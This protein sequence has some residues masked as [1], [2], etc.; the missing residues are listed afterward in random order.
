MEQICNK[1]KENAI[2]VSAL[3]IGIALVLGTYIVANSF[4]RVKALANVVSVTGSA[5]KVIT[6][7]IVKWTSSCSRTV[8][9]Y[10]LKSGSEKIKDDLSIIVSYLKEKGVREEDITIDPV[11]V[12]TTCADYN[13]YSYDKFGNRLCAANQISGYSLQQTI[14]IESSD[15][16][17]V[18]KLAQNATGD[19]INK[20]VIFSSQN[21]EYY[22]K[23][24]ADL[25]VEMLSEATKNAKNRAEKIANSTGAKIGFL[26]SA[27]MGVFQVTS[28]NSTEISDYGNFDTSAIEKKVTAVV[29]A[30]FLLK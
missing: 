11:K 29:R 14:I 16:P 12:S 17:G 9:V 27:S 23:N 22:Y 1:I 19:L 6:S 28:T 8:G 10:D 7:D 25:K 4:Y 2:V 13:N 3:V 24:F 20:G 15:V 21:L 26:Q 30:S 18:T 5:E